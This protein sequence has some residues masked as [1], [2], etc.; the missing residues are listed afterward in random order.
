MW[1]KHIKSWIM[2]VTESLGY[3]SSRPIRCWV[4]EKV[5]FR[6]DSAWCVV[7]VD[8]SAVCVFKTEQVSLR[9]PAVKLAPCRLWRST[10]AK[11]SV[12]Q[13]RRWKQEENSVNRA[14][15]KGWGILEDPPADCRLLCLLAFGLSQPTRKGEKIHFILMLSR[16]HTRQT[17]SIAT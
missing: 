17:V 10:V 1:I 6:H 16:S 3:I 7:A 14:N 5:I 9:F 13:S 4:Q 2:F 11:E 12:G 8:I 15:V